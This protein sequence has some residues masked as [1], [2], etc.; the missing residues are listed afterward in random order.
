MRLF[1]FLVDWRTAVAITMGT[2]SQEDRR[3]R[4]LTTA[5]PHQHMLYEAL[6]SPKQAYYY[7]PA[8]SIIKYGMKGA[9]FG[10]C[11]LFSYSVYWSFKKTFFFTCCMSAWCSHPA[12]HF[13]RTHLFSVCILA[14]FF[15]HINHFRPTSFSHEDDPFWKS[16]V[17]QWQNYPEVRA[18]KPCVFLAYFMKCFVK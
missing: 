2:F 1:L 8:N 3:C 14:C 7:Y 11:L 18:L 10:V 16:P 17:L 4:I 15:V 9:T 6:A 13:L 12:D 5:H